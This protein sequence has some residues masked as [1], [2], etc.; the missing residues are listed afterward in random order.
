MEAELRHLA[1]Y[2]KGI[3]QKEDFLPIIKEAKEYEYIGK[4]L[5]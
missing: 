2:S 1:N 4:L 3:I 5:N